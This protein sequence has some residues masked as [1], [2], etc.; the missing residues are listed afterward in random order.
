MIPSPHIPVG[1]SGICLETHLVQSAVDLQCSETH[2]VQSAVDLRCSETH[3]VQSA[4][5]TGCLDE[6]LRDPPNLETC[7]PCHETSQEMAVPPMCCSS[8][9]YVYLSDKKFSL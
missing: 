2:L 4:Q 8:L 9:P 5:N 3:L 7:G 1:L 6:V